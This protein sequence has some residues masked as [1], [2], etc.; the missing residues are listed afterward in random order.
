VTAAGLR[1]LHRSGNPLVLPN[2]WDAASAKLVEAAGFAAVATSS[3]AVAESL[4]YSDHQGAPLAEMFDAARRIARAVVVPVT[5]DAEGG[6]GLPAGE[7][8]ARLADAGAVGCNIEDTDHAAGGGLVP[9]TEQADRLAALCQAAG[10]ALVVNAR[11]DVFLGAADEEAALPQAIERAQ[12]YL[13]A[14]AHCVYPI[15]IRSADVMTAF[16]DA[17]APGAVNVTYLAGGPDVATLA[18]TGVARISLGT[19]LW[20][21]AQASLRTALTDLAGGVMPY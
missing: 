7:L 2:A 4:G 17:V 21:F 15:H 5:V 18:T 11:I 12:A 20:R 3:G 16:V 8:A 13:A 10:D 14:G 19:G 9:V 6:Y 1:E